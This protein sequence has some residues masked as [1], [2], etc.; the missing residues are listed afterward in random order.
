MARRSRTVLL[1]RH[2]DLPSM[3]GGAWPTWVAGYVG[4]G[5]SRRLQAGRRWSSRSRSAGAVMRCSGI[6]RALEPLITI[7]HSCCDA[8]DQRLDG[9]QRQPAAGAAVVGAPGVR[10][11]SRSGGRPAA[12]GVVPRIGDALL[13]AQLGEHVG[14]AVEQAS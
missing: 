1:G 4:G 7:G 6:D 10:L 9:S 5:R 14:H 3:R 12:V 2:L 13:Q 8:G 11:A